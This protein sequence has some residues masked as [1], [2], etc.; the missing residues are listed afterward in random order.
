M[1]DRNMLIANL[2]VSG[3]GLLFLLCLGL[4]IHYITKEVT[5]IETTKRMYLNETV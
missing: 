4:T 2:I 5:K 3:I 1:N